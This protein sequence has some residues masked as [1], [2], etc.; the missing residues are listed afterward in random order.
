VLF[1][2]GYVDVMPL[3]S[4]QLAQQRQYIR[5]NPRSRLLRSTHRDVLQPQRGGID[6]ALTVNGLWKYLRDVCAPWQLKPAV[7]AQIESRLLMA[8]DDTRRGK[9][10]GTDGGGGGASDGSGRSGG[11][12]GSSRSD[13][14]GGSGASGKIGCDSYGNRVLLQRRLLPVVCHGQ[15][16]ELFARQKAECLRAAREG[17]VL[18]S[19]RIAPGEQEIIDAALEGGL[20]VV[21]VTDNGMPEIFHPS[22]TRMAQ[23]L[24]D[25]LL[26]V[27]PWRYH[28]RSAEEGISVAMCKTMNCVAQAICRQ[29]DDWWKTTGAG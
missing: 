19:A 6:T 26:I 11:S 14:S 22:E 13:T 23:C 25:Q 9:P 21:L 18:V 8:N 12:S 17:A 2:S 24:A 5:N 20:P 15:D 29:R 7:M 4:G 27:T 16:R 10:A 3:R 1:A 28:Y